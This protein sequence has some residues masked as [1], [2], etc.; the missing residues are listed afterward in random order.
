MK[1]DLV[2]VPFIFSA[3]IKMKVPSTQVICVW[4]GG[5]GPKNDVLKTISSQLIFRISVENPPPPSPNCGK[6]L[7]KFSI[8][9]PAIFCHFWGQNTKVIPSII[10]FLDVIW[11]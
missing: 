2:S 11:T 4:G 9:N 1:T 3:L 8:E 6:S 7:C 5:G 10:S